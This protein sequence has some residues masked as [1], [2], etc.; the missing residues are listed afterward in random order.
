MTIAQFNEAFKIFQSD[1]DLSN[2]DDSVLYGC[3]LS[4]FEPVVITVEVLAKF[5]RWQ[6]QLFNGGVDMQELNDEKELFCGKRTRHKF[7]IV[8]M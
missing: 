7:T 3:G 6:L 5:M 8:G 2:V 1:A 4:Y